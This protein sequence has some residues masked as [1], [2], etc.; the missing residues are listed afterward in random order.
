MWKIISTRE[1]GRYV[2]VSGDV[3][4]H[5]LVC[6]KYMGATHKDLD[7]YFIQFNSGK[8]VKLLDFINHYIEVS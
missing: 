6:A 3:F 7:K 2:W 8:E 5:L 1:E 4:A